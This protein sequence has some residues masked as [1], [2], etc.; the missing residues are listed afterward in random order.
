MQ[1]F[2]IL[3][4]KTLLRLLDALAVLSLQGDTSTE[5]TFSHVAAHLFQVFFGMVIGAFS[6]GNAAPNIQSLGVARGAAFT[7]YSIIDLVS[8][9]LIVQHKYKLFCL[10]GMTCESNEH[11]DKDENSLSSFLGF[12]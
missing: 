8:T 7:I 9:H 1:S 12:S 4:T 6:L 11:T 2:F 10:K 3:T 5:G